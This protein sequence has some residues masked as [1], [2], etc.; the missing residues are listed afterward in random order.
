[1]TQV[2]TFGNTIL[3]GSG[4]RGILKPMSDGSGYTRMNAGGF[5]IPNRGGVVYS[6]N[7]YL[8][9][10]MSPD[11]DLNR[12]VSEGQVFCELGHPPQF[13]F[14]RVNGVVVRTPITEL[15]EWINRLRT[16]M[17]PNVCAHIRKIHWTMTGGDKDP[18]HNEVELTPFGEHKAWTADAL[19][20]PDIN[21]AISLRSV[22]KPQKMGDMVREVEYLSTYDVVVEQG[23]MRACKHLSAGLESYLDGAINDGFN[24]MTTT[25]D[26]LIHAV[27]KGFKNDAIMA[28]FEGTESFNRVNEM[29]GVLMKMQRS[30][31]IRLV[32]SNS[33]DVFR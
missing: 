30:A 20:N 24:E 32:S 13:Y 31:P 8:K 6:F 27:D 17:M 3:A 11:S 5:N 16:I 33:L 9:E 28:R 26:E 29:M 25:L 1:M 4:K 2:I 15:F 14:E 12:R 21:F 18:V 23:V 7:N 10:C 22:T 19:A